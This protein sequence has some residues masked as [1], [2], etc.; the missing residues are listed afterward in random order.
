MQMQAE[1]ESFMPY[2]GAAGTSI[3]RC[4]SRYAELA[5]HAK[6][7]GSTP[8]K[9][10][11]AK[12]LQ[13]HTRIIRHE[14]YNR[15]GVYSAQRSRT[16]FDILIERRCFNQLNRPIKRP[17]NAELLAAQLNDQQRLAQAK[18]LHARYCFTTDDYIGTIEL[19]QQVMS[20]QKNSTKSNWL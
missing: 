8:Q 1:E 16:Q 9:K 2:R 5:Y 18:L 14:Y 3:W 17:G 6:Y 7:A 13:S 11:L 10:G 19:S 12:W 15:A 20:S 4:Q